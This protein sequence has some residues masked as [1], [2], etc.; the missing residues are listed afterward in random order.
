MGRLKREAK[1]RR[2]GVRIARPG[3][4]ATDRFVGGFQ[5]RWRRERSGAAIV[6]ERREACRVRGASHEPQREHDARKNRCAKHSRRHSIGGTLD[7][8]P[9]LRQATRALRMRN[10]SENDASLHGTDLRLPEVDREGATDMSPEANGAVRFVRTF[11][12]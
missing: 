8:A 12:R 5:R 10:G 2:L 4:G 1:D 7:Q 9:R 6:T 3:R 11:S